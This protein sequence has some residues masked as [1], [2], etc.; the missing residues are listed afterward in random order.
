M[1][2]LH[3]ATLLCLGKFQ[4]PCSGDLGHCAARFP[5]CHNDVLDWPAAHS[6]HRHHSHL[7]LLP[8]PRPP[9]WCQAFQYR[10]GHLQPPPQTRVLLLGV[11]DVSGAWRRVH[12]E[13]RCHQCRPGQ[14][15]LWAHWSARC[16]STVAF[17]KQGSPA[18]I[19]RHPAARTDT[20][21][22]Q[23]SLPLFPPSSTCY[24]ENQ[25]RSDIS[26]AYLRVRQM[27]SAVSPED[28]GGVMLS[29]V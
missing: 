5:W 21:L 12:L 6:P 16:F 2:E 18:T 22:A 14:Q 3:V 15:H 10:H 11:S 28:L 13:H 29:T 27:G 1:H 20:A 4:C 7:Y 26:F 25:R 8:F 9:Q 19:L 24:W 23:P 17:L